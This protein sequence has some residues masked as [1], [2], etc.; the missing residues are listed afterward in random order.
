MGEGDDDWVMCGWQVGPMFVKNITGGGGSEWVNVA[1]PSII[2]FV[3]YD[4]S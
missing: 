4:D 1:L 2:P 3:R